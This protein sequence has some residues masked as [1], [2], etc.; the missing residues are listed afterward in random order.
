M[1]GWP[2]KWNRGTP[3]SDGL[4]MACWLLS[5]EGRDKVPNYALVKYNEGWQI[6][7]FPDAPHYWMEVTDPADD[8]ALMEEYENQLR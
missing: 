3:Q 8:F 5:G 2:F 7:D 4:Y 1:T 6:G